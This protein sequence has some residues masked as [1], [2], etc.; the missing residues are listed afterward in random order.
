MDRPARKLVFGIS[1]KILPVA[2]LDMVLSKKQIK[3]TLIR[4]RGCAGWS[5]PVLF[6]NPR[7]QVF[8]CRGPNGKS[9]IFNSVGLDLELSIM[10]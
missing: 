3:K 7:R 4:Q 6:G 1:D 5:A 2:K 10:A 8:S 9:D